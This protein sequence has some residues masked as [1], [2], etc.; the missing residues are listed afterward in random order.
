MQNLLLTPGRSKDAMDRAVRSVF[1]VYD[2]RPITEVLWWIIF[3]N[4]IKICCRIPAA[5]YLVHC[6]Y[7]CEIERRVLVLPG[8]FDHALDHSG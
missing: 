6:R 1:A 8:L 3:K 4:V 2:D 7:G 5:K